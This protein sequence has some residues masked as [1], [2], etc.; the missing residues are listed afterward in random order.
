MKTTIP[1]TDLQ[2]RLK[3]A[4]KL[5]LQAGQMLM[6]ARNS[7]RF[8]S[9]YKAHQELVTSTDEEID[10]WLVTRLKAAFPDDQILS[11]EGNTESATAEQAAA[12]WILDPIDGTVNFAHGQP[13]VAIS[14]GLYAYGVP[15]LGVVHSPFLKETFV[16]L[17]G[18]GAMKNNQPISVS[19]LQELRPAL[20]ATGFPYDKTQL[21][22]LIRRLERVLPKCQDLRRCGSAALDICHVADG[23]LDGYYESLSLW[24]FAAAVLIAEEAGA[25]LSHLYSSALSFYLDTRDWVI[26]TPAIHEPLKALL[27]EADQS[28]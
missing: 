15:Q 16:A 11:E 24:D 21:A 9:N 28:N 14:I 17:R 1:V 5:A 20:I 12:L 19:G 10:T 3:I 25:Q 8:K 13:H 23:S 27:L 18:Q 2:N 4:E 26:T 22:P 6:Q 7:G